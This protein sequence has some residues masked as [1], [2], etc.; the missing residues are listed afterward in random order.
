MEEELPT[1]K[2]LLLTTVFFTRV[3]RFKVCSLG[4]WVWCSGTL[5]Q[6]RLWKYSPR[7]KTH[8]QQNRYFSACYFYYY[9]MLFVFFLPVI[10]TP[11]ILHPSA[12][13]PQSTA[14]L[15]ALGFA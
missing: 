9:Y 15:M 12:L 14:K 8:F 7:P 10:P 2:G 11:R 1:C 13:T 6:V 4:L 3:F 5:F